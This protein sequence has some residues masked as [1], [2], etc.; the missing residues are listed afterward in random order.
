[1]VLR[2]VDQR[3]GARRPLLRLG[4][5]LAADGVRKICCLRPFACSNLDNG[6]R[7]KQYEQAQ[8]MIQARQGK[9]NGADWWFASACGILS[10][11]LEKQLK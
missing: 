8:N 10:R 4:D 2:M 7:C 1:M 9:M 5:V 3:R 11:E 6:T